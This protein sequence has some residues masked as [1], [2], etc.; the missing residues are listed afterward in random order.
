MP[1]TGAT[2]LVPNTE[3]AAHELTRQRTPSARQRGTLGP[4]QAHPL[5][6]RD[7]IGEATELSRH[8]YGRAAVQHAV[9][10][11]RRAQRCHVQMRG[12]A[13]QHYALA[14]HEGSLRPAYPHV[15]AAWQRIRAAGA[16]RRRCR[17]A[18]WGVGEPRPLWCW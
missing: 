5:C 13:L 3:Y 7:D 1:T 12:H 10:L 8:K 11:R 17:A 2:F 14:S 15:A 18:V 16:R 9:T 6:C 4:L